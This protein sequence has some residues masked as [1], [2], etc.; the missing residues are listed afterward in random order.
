LGIDAT[1][2]KADQRQVHSVTG[3]HIPNL[4]DP[5]S[6]SVRVGST[7]QG[8]S[9][10]LYGTPQKPMF[11]SV[12]TETMIDDNQAVVMYKSHPITEEIITL[13][14]ALMVLIIYKTF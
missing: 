7:D 1:I 6:L 14:A 13:S 8:R 12:I 11:I 10:Y 3:E 4:E 5:V 9:H 2:T